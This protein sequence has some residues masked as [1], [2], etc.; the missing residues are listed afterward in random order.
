MDDRERTG[1]TRALTCDCVIAGGGPAGMIA[2]L[3]LAR[4]GVRVTVLEKHHDFL[5]D[6][7]GD[8]VHP[9]TLGLLD[10]LGLMEQ[11][12]A[13]GATRVEEVQ[14]PVA[15]G[16]S[17]RMA[18]FRRLPVKHPYIAMIPQWDFL[19]V[20]ATAGEAE[21]NF[22]LLMGAE[23]TG[24]RWEGEQ[25]VGVTAVHDGAALDVAA[26]LTLAADG[27]WSTLRAASSLPI[28][29]HPVDADVWWFRL[30][31]RENPG[32]S[33]E[34]LLPRSIAGQLYIGIPR[35]DY[36]QVARV[37]PKGADGRMRAQGIEQIRA[38]AASAFPEL[39]RAASHLELE[40]LKLLDVRVN[41][42]R[43]WHRPGLLCIGDAAHAM[44]PI[45][46]VGINLAVQDGVAAARILAEP[47]RRGT[48]GDRHVA[49]AQRRRT[50]PTRATQL[51]QRGLHRGV[52][53]LLRGNAQL[54][55]PVPVARLVS[56]VPAL[57]AVPA[58]AVGVGVRPEHAP[59]AARRPPGMTQ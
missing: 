10:E 20:L 3:L 56:A 17:V 39:E 51:L 18:D 13:L 36:L 6:F 46:G 35:R 23:V 15:G 11:F 32:V 27:R 34:S 57:A 5:R 12:G 1:P 8:T 28:M 26:R 2:G 7:R 31:T 49:A 43:Q 52:S 48:I 21:P 33:A 38:D 54:Q 19:D 9:S 40:D 50:L 42:L 22:T 45:G 59:A 30:P 14:A 44:S 41:R 29:D 47:L 4:S 58:F 37:I 24:L 53:R 16:G 25:V 55:I